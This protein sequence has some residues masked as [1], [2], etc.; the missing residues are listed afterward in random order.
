MREIRKLDGFEHE[1]EIC[2]NVTSSRLES[3]Q[4]TLLQQMDTLKNDLSEAR[5]K[6]NNKRLQIED[7]S[8]ERRKMSKLTQMSMTSVL[9]ADQSVYSEGGIKRSTLS[10]NLGP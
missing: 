2:D 6:L 4:S 7:L 9:S 1:F 3:K 8:R 5:I 10:P